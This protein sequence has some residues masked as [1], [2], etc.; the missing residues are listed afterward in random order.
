[1]WTK[2]VEVWTKSVEVWTKSVEV[3]IIGGEHNFFARPFLP[4]NFNNHNLD[5]SIYKP[6]KRSADAFVSWLLNKYNVSHAPPPNFEKVTN[7][8]QRRISISIIHRSDRKI[9]NIKELFP[10]FNLFSMDAK[11][12]SLQGISFA[13]QVLG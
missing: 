5:V 6:F 13:E 3:C 9:V 1:M 12:Y 11:I 7:C 10:L 2:S 8:Q 4:I